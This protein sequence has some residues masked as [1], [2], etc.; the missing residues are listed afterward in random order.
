MWSHPR[1]HRDQRDNPRAAQ[2]KELCDLLAV[3]EDDIFIFSDKRIEWRDKGNLDVAWKR[4]YRS[5]IEES[6]GA[7]L[8]AERW[9]RQQSG[10]VFAD[11][12]C[13]K[14]L[15]VALPDSNK[16][17]YHRILVAHGAAAACRRHFGGGSGSL[18]VDTSIVGA[19]SPFTVGRVKK[20]ALFAHVL[21]EATLEI[22]LANL[23]TIPEFRDY[24]LAKE[25]L[26]DRGQHII[27]TGEEDLLAFYLQNGDG[28]DSGRHGFG[29]TSG[30]AAIAV[31]E[32][33][34]DDFQRSPHKAARDEANE[35]S[36]SWDELVD[37][38]AKHSMAGTQYTTTAKDPQD[39][40]RTLRCLNG[41]PRTARRILVDVCKRAL[42]SMGPKHYRVWAAEP[43]GPSGVHYVFLALRQRDGQSYEEYRTVRANLLAHCTAIRRTQTPTGRVHIGVA[44]SP[45]DQ[46]TGS[47]DVVRFDGT[48]WT[49]EDAEVARK[50]QDEFGILQNLRRV[51]VRG[52]EYP[53]PKP[54][55][56]P[57]GGERNAP[58]PCGSGMKW[59]KCC[60]SAS[61]TNQS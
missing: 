21:D 61:S 36:Y 44:M 12:E 39:T 53:P 29:N 7:V 16:T 59:K 9:L 32:G 40:E 45:P 38:F 33:Q 28:T 8:G 50:F 4:W 37:R 58:C 52:H 55:V 25:A 18:L 57:R 17:R 14:P 60:G 19:T 11:K 13:T 41:E 34:W 15:P 42:R 56:P 49:P 27:A 31:I 23:D 51:P 2:G 54:M 1:P 43:T 22:V 10:R 3:F 26:I 46:P 5:A 24:L 30:V 20:D 35:D 6:Y 48:N 47:E